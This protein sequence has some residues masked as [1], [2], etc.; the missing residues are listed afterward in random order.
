[1][2]KYFLDNDDDGHWYLVPV[3]EREA[4]EEWL[5]SDVDEHHIF[6]A[7]AYEYMIGGHP[8]K[9]EFYLDFDNGETTCVPV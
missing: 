3:E 1:M 9:I 5:D 2:T 4:F 8:N 6:T 7:K